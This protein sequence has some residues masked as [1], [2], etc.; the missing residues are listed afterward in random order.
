MIFVRRTMQY[1][2]AVAK[3]GFIQRLAKGASV[4]SAISRKSMKGVSFAQSE[5]ALL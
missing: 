3:S 4:E 5:G 2:S 1:G